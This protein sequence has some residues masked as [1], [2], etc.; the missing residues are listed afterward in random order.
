MK[1][2]HILESKLNEMRWGNDF[3]AGT[4]TPY[5]EDE[6]TGEVFEAT[7]NCDYG[8]PFGYWPIDYNGT[9][10]FSIGDAYTTH[11]N[12]CGKCAEK[13]YYDT[14]G[15]SLYDESN[16]IAEAIENFIHWFKEYN[17]RYNEEN[18][19][20][21]S[22]DGEEEKDV[23][24]FIDE[25]REEI[26]DEHI[27]CYGYIEEF[28]ENFLE[29]N[30]SKVPYSTDVQQYLEDQI[31]DS[32]DFTERRGIDDAMQMFG[33]DFYDFFEMGHSEGRIWPDLEMIGFYDTQQPGPRELETILYNLSDGLELDY[34][35]LLQY[36]IVFE[37]WNTGDGEVT[38]C[39]VADYID[40]NYGPD[41][42]D[43][44]EDGDTEHQYARQG[45]TVFVPH[46][47][48]QKDKREFFK[49]FRDVRDKAI[50]VPQERGAGTV[51]RY[52][53]LRYPYGE[54]RE[55]TMSLTES[56]LHYIVKE[57]VKNILE[58]GAWSKYPDKDITQAELDAN[59]NINTNGD[60]ANAYVRKDPMVNNIHGSTLRD[61]LKASMG[62]GI[63]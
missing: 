6:K 4:D 53:A 63:R 54:N 58:G 56:D 11:V 16:E 41:E 55:R 59:M 50:F 36:H 12:A 49:D 60:F 45:K 27:D 5:Y 31:A 29:G 43:E 52:H 37:N 44:E 40:E 48:N 51:A 9:E 62:N 34:D 57:A 39:T 3:C 1:K 24:D 30:V 23:S 2:I 46:L 14:I 26:Y 38:A 7:W 25:I 19:N 13:Y 22:E 33:M 17:Y 61:M 21:V 47:A 28:V 18:D 35:D 42:E 8:Y 32:Y 15:E 10:E 20:W